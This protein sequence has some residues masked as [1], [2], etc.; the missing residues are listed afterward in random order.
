MY[1]TG[2]KVVERVLRRLE[3][4]FIR[5]T[6][7]CESGG[8]GGCQC[9]CDDGLFH[10]KSTL[11]VGCSLIKLAARCLKRLI[12]VKKNES[13]KLIRVYCKFVIG[14]VQGGLKLTNLNFFA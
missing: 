3:A 13:G 6:S 8:C 2:G 12:Y 9:Q 1:K 10:L 4:L 11:K 7:G 5:I 14:E